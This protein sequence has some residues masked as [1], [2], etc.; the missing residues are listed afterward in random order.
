M[1]SGVAIGVNKAELNFNNVLRGGY[2]QDSIIVSTDTSQD[3]FIER[4]VTGEISDWVS[5][6]S[7]E[8]ILRNGGSDSLKVIVKPPKDIA[9]GIYLGELKL[10][11]SPLFKTTSGNIG[12]AIRTS[13]LIKLKITI[14]GDEFISC[15]VAGFEIDDSE[16]TYPLIFHS[17]VKNSGNV[18]IRPDFKINI[19][20]QEQSEIVASKSLVYSFNILPTLS[21][22]VTSVLGGVNL[23]VGQYWAEIASSMCAGSGFITFNI[24]EKGEIVDLG[25]LFS[26]KNSLWV[27]VGDIVPISAIFKNTGSRSESVK[28]KGTIKLAGQIIKV[29]DTDAVLVDPG[30][31]VSLET[32]FNPK[33]EGQYIINLRALYN[34]KLTFWKSSILNAKSSF[35]YDQTLKDLKSKQY[36]SMFIL[37]IIIIVILLLLIIIKKKKKKRR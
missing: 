25:E 6:G 7:E 3:V 21:E 31:S 24:L 19:W 14:V 17:S 28:L 8:L 9:N 15:S 13:F 18:Q 27:Q 22:Q 23:D 2:A 20:N 30:Q 12:S 1:V 16:I 32:F 10:L 4:I 26:V 5:F 35:I 11:T 29:V 36:F 37:I 33:M 34:N